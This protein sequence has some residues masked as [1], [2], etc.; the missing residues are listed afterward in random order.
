LKFA[1][2]HN[3]GGLKRKGAANALISFESQHA[4]E[5]LESEP[6]VPFFV[7]YHVIYL[8]GQSERN[9]LASDSYVV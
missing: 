8:Q 5:V 9:A 6:T 1:V 4:L 3:S 2:A 7:V